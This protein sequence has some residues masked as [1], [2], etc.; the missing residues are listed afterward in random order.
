MKST[1]KKIISMALLVFFILW[2]VYYLNSHS[3]DFKQL[4]LVN[5]AYIFY[6]IMINFS[7][8]ITNGLL[9]KYFLEPF[10]IH[11]NIK[12]WFGLSILTSFY[13][14][15]TPFR[16][17]SIAR[18]SYL[19]KKHGFSYASFLSTLIGIY[20]INVMIAS[21]LGIISMVL[22]YLKFDMFNYL[23][24]F[25][26]IGLFIS[27]L[28]IV[29]I[30]PNLS[31]TQNKVF[32]VLIRVINGWHLIRKN[33]KLVLTVSTIMVAQLMLGVLGT[34]LVYGLFDAHIGLI[35]SMF[36]VSVSYLG[37]FISITPGALGISEAV[38]VFSALIVGI[39]PS[40]SLAAAL[41]G[42]AIS[43]VLLIITGPLFSYLLFKRKI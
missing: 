34:I 2:F 6:F 14:T 24:L 17:G 41:T 19:K 37:N 25:I 18:A 40:Q 36:L 35:K 22:L 11:L 26:F 12:E 29:I 42:R 1:I 3:S 33:N 39:T 38:Q 23:I 8:Y 9:I 10:N 15:I 20:V 21:L 7:F 5:S 16:G 27:T 32:N 4:S 31:N 28:I 30:S 13:N 43:L